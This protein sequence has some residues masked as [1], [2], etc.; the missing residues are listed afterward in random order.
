MGDLQQALY[1]GDKIY[2][3]PFDLCFL[4]DDEFVLL[5]VWLSEGF[6]ENEM[7]GCERDDIQVNFIFGGLKSDIRPTL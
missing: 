4:W 2:F 5:E 6:E 7:S 3:H 1:L